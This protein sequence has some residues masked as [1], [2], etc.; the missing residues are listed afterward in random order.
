M[1]GLGVNVRVMIM[2]VVG[3]R[4]R[5]R[6]GYEKVRVRNVWKPFTQDG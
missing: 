6:D 1:L 5:V 3:V 2:A 4:V